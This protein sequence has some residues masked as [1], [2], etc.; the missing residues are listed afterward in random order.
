MKSLWKSATAVLLSSAMAISGISVTGI[1]MNEVVAAERGAES[2]EIMLATFWT[3]DEDCTDTLY[4]S[5][6]GENFYELTQPYVDATPNDAG[7]MVMEGIP[8]GRSDTTLHDPSI[9]YRDGYFWML[10][11][12]TTGEGDNQ[13]FVPMMGYSDDL[14]HW[15]YPA[16]GS[17]TNVKVSVEP[18][19]YKEKGLNKWD[20]VAPDF[21][22][23]DDGTVYIVLSL[24]Y[25]AM[26][27][28]DDSANDVMQPY[29]IKVS[30][31]KLRPEADTVN[32]PAAPPMA[33]YEDA[34]PINLPCM[35]ERANVAHNHIDGSLYKEGD[36][37]YLSIKENGVTNEIYRIKDLSKCDDPNAWE[38]VC[39]DVVTGYEGPCLTKYQGEYFFYADRLKTYTP[40]DATQPYGTDETW[41]IKAT[42][43]TTGKLDEYTGWL[44]DN[45]R[46]IK[47]YDL[48]GKERANR[49]GTVITVTGEAAEK[50]RSLAKEKGYTDAQLSNSYSASNWEDGGWYYQESYRTPKLSGN[51]VKYWYEGGVR[52]GIDFS[53]PDYRGKE[54]YDPDSDAWYWLEAQYN[55]RLAVA[56]NVYD[57]NG[58]WVK[59]AYEMGE[60]QIAQP[61]DQEKYN[62]YGPEL[63]GT[64]D[65]A[66]KWVRYDWEGKMIKSNDTDSRFYVDGSNGN[67]YRYDPITGAMQKGLW[68]YIN[69]NGDVVY[70]YFDPTTGVR[71]A[72][73]TIEI[74]GYSYVFDEYGSLM[75]NES[76]P[77]GKLPVIE[78]KSPNIGGEETETTPDAEYTGYKDPAAS[79]D[80]NGWHEVY[81]VNYW[82]ENG[83]RQGYNPNNDA[84]RGKEIFDPESNAWYWLDNV[85]Q[86]AVAKSKD[87]YQESLAGEWGDIKGEDGQLYGKWV[88][89]DAEGHMIKGWNEKDG[90]RYFFDYTYGTMV[91][92]EVVIDEEIYY[93]DEATGILQE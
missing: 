70:C 11:G 88:R 65:S 21:M 23:D 7:S 54:I 32:N 55:G 36:Y 16:S 3:S 45:I 47:T 93:F 91:K 15:S 46:R 13:R 27:H 57:E 41:V 42:I 75:V 20:A 60:R 39:Y 80:W 35:T 64:D 44:E 43:D 49:H 56:S 52:Q 59:S 5:T 9:I 28:G 77:I 74:D 1:G 19:G 31:L 25:Y 53:N 66:W 78:Y 50:V 89:Y 76:G 85:Q 83:L 90:N 14:E 24:G 10:S 33:E 17:T 62:T 72:N 87:V 71:Y 22:V 40:V 8:A 92:G 2:D 6:D 73:Q 29:L 69:D 84:Y 12:F 63:Y 61:V 30:N 51:V 68:S 37:Y 86:G 48:E 34:V 82:Y 81:G 18:K 58:N 79:E 67:W 4:W 26:F 38:E